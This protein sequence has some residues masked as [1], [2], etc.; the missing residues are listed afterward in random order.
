[1][2]Y[3]TVYGILAITNPFK[4][5]SSLIS[6][7]SIRPFGAQNLAQKLLTIATALNK[8]S[9]ELKEEK[10][11]LNRPEIAARIEQW[12]EIKYDYL[13]EKQ[14]HLGTPS[15]MNNPNKLEDIFAE[16][17]ANNWPSLLDNY[18]NL[19]ESEQKQISKV[20]ELQK[21][22]K[23]KLE[24]IELFGDEDLIELIKQVFPMI[25]QP[26][27]EI[28]S[29]AGFPEWMTSFF[30]WYKALY[31]IGEKKSRTEEQTKEEIL[32]ALLELEQSQY[33]LL[34]NIVKAD[35]NQVFSQGLNWFLSKFKI[36]DGL[37]IELDPLIHSLSS[38]SK[39]KIQDELD[40][41]IAFN[42]F[43]D[44]LWEVDWKRA[45]ELKSPPHTQITKYLLKDF[46]KNL[47]KMLLACDH[48]YSL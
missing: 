46:E 14:P 48:K 22:K 39:Q 7:F 24:L 5:A 26:L 38:D 29:S 37:S 2:T 4:M 32:R 12:V 6:L 10:K 27:G 34:R 28:Y 11:I 9:S 30:K 40:T 42:R 43:R 44:H 47:K 8:T 41:L 15:E 25:C 18:N 33:Q 23:E 13:E 20:L 1:M 19:T 3:R 21:R 35:K 36:G 45:N 17:V 16:D 31:T